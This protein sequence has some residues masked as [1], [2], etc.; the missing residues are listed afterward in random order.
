MH[1]PYVQVAAMAQQF[2]DEGPE[3][4]ISFIKRCK[5]VLG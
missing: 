1:L 3:S 4:N 5:Q 2:Y